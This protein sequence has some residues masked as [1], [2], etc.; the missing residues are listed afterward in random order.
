MTPSEMMEELR[1][2][3]DGIFTQGYLVFV[4]SIRPEW[5]HETDVELIERAITRLLGEGN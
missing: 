2:H 3:P 5:A 4:R 1:E